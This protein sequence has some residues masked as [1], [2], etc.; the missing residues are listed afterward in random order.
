MTVAQLISKCDATVTGPHAWSWEIIDGVAWF[1]FGPSWGFWEWARNFLCIPVPWRGEWAHLGYVLEFEHI[2][3]EL[4]DAMS[5][6]LE[7]FGAPVVWAG[8]SQG[9]AIAQLAQSYF[10]GLLVIAGSPRAFLRDNTWPK[11]QIIAGRDIVT[12]LPPWCK[13]ISGKVLRVA[14]EERDPLKSHAA[15]YGCEVEIPMP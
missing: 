3:K 7:T 6:T 8:Y 9:G 15:Y 14:T 5:D 10:G 1:F 13:P 4:S 12:T 2:R 11:A